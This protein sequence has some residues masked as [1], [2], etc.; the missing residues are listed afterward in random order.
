MLTCRINRTGL[1]VALFIRAFDGN[2]SLVITNYLNCE[3]QE[4]ALLADSVRLSNNKGYI[5]TQL[6]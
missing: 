3:D 6:L 1:S 4:R 5:P 2:V